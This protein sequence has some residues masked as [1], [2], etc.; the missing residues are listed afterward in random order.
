M[1]YFFVLVLALACLDEEV[2]N[3]ILSK[4]ESPDSKFL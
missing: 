1:G 3:N 4:K 2:L